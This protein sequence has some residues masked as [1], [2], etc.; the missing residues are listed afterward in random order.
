[1]F[2]IIVGILLYTYF[3][4]KLKRNYALIHHQERGTDIEDVSTGDRS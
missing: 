2:I 3:V 1:M 4:I